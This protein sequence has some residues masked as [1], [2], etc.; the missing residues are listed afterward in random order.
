MTKVPIPFD[1]VDGFVEAYY[2]RPEALLDPPCAARS[3]RGR[4][5][6]PRWSSAG[7][8]A[9]ARRWSRAQWDAR[10]GHLRTQ[11]TYIGALRLLVAKRWKRR[12]TPMRRLAPGEPHR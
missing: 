8:S 3:R 12:A 11:P 10:H 6:S 1:C 9:C 4:S 5:S 7:S 2:A